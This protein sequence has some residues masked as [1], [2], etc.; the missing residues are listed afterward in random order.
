M[1][2]ILNG[3]ADLW[4]RDCVQLQITLLKR[5]S[6]TLS[7]W[8]KTQRSLLQI[9]NVSNLFFSLFF[10]IKS[11]A[12]VHLR[13]PLPQWWA[14]VRP[15]WDEFWG[16]SGWWSWSSCRP[17]RR[18][19]GGGTLTAARLPLTQMSSCGGL[20]WGTY[21][22]YELYYWNK[23]VRFSLALRLQRAGSRD[24]SSIRSSTL[25]VQSLNK[26]VPFFK[27]TAVASQ[28]SSNSVLFAA[29]FLKVVE[30]F[31]LLPRKRTM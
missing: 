8:R 18:T 13:V 25:H 16:R 6:E 12:E 21:M 24:I 31:F 10:S 27:R 22:E 20:L 5:L 19:T 30:F 2:K 3:G 7:P 14:F 29:P 26:N 1:P 4:A 9:G 11:V 23:P 15:W 17:R 28:P